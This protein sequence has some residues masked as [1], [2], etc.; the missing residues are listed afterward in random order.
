MTIKYIFT[1]SS[2]SGW[3][4]S[5]D[6]LPIRWLVG[7]IVPS[8]L[9][10]S[11]HGVMWILVICIERKRMWLF[12]ISPFHLLTSFL[13]ANGTKWSTKY[14]RWCYVFCNSSAA[15]KKD[16][17]AAKLVLPEAQFSINNRQNAVKLTVEP[18]TIP[19]ELWPKPVSLHHN[20]L[21]D[22]LPT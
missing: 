13:R 3:K 8:S 17:N 10:K 21:T 12:H 9:C 22:T 20:S 19:T 11:L 5:G 1:F 14:I 18:F 16:G 7:H 2:K 6:A 4:M 15:M